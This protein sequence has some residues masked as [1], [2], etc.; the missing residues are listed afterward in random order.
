MRE[1]ER[2]GWVWK[3]LERDENGEGEGVV[4]WLVNEQRL[5]KN[6]IC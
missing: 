2:N 3:P 5:K 1:K 6:M 4:W